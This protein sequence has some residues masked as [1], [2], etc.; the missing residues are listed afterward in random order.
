MLGQI[1]HEF[2]QYYNRLKLFVLSIGVR[3]DN[4][5][6]HWIIHLARSNEPRIDSTGLNAAQTQS[7]NSSSNA[8]TSTV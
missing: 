2:N 1:N 4:N 7:A 5:F 8:A 3:H 6:Q